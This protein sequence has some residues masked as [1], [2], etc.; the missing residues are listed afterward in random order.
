[1][2]GKTKYMKIKKL[3]LGALAAATMATSVGVANTPV[4]AAE[5]NEAAIVTNQTSIIKAHPDSSLKDE[6][7]FNHNGFTYAYDETDDVYYGLAIQNA[8]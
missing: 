8:E 3:F 7:S 2:K 1:M 4:F 6:T 5:Q